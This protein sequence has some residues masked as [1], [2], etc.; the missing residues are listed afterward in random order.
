MREQNDIYG[1]ATHSVCFEY[2]LRWVSVT[3]EILEKNNIVIDHTYLALS[4]V[5][6]EGFIN[7]TDMKQFEWDKEDRCTNANVWYEAGGEPKP[8]SLKIFTAQRP[9][10]KWT[11]SFEVSTRQRH[12]AARPKLNIV[13]GYK[14]EDSAATSA[15][16]GV[17][18]SLRR[19]MRD[20]KERPTDI[21]C[22]RDAVATVNKMI[23]RRERAESLN[24]I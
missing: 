3:M 15:L 8:W 24:G 10:G 17:S 13:G 18:R 4:A 2:W 12:F 1:S 7:T 20:T 19:A 5:K 9:D 16:I 11:S 22:Y 6:L 14:T 21:R 23:F